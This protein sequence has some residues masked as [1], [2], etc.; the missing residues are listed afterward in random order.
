MWT[1]RGFLW[2]NTLLSTP[3]STKFFK[4]SFLIPK[5]NKNTSNQ[6]YYEHRTQFFARNMDS[7]V[8]KSFYTSTRANSPYVNYV[9]TFPW[10]M[11]ITFYYISRSVDF[12]KMAAKR[13]LRQDVGFNKQRWWEVPGRSPP[14]RNEN[15][16][17]LNLS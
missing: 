3:E 7:N 15:L 2:W 13:N 6:G 17:S 1:I 12:L 4:F 14:D 10:G 9:M 11:S 16:A 8:Y 5:K